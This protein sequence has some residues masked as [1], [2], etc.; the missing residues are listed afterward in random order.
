MLTATKET[1]LEEIRTFLIANRNRVEQA[2][3]NIQEANA[4][5]ATAQTKYNA[6]TITVDAMGAELFEVQRR[7]SDNR[8]VIA[9]MKAEQLG[10]PGKYAEH[11]KAI[12]GTSQ[13][14]VFAWEAVIAAR[15][16]GKMTD[17][18]AASRTAVDLSIAAATVSADVN[19]QKTGLYLNDI[20][21]VAAYVQ[22]V[23]SALDVSVA[24]DPKPLETHLANVAKYASDTA[25]A[26][27]A[28]AKV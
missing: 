27:G 13:E 9:Q 8:A 25:A 1:A 16:A 20:D 14:I 12:L 11:L 7:I 28:I 26:V 22:T 10:M 23:V 5:I 4:K 2:V 15:I 21:T 3:A 6:G 19:I 17:M 24:P 18:I